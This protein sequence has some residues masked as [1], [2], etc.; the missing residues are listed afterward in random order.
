V[1]ALLF[2]HNGASKATAERAGLTLGW[3]AGRRHPDSTAVRLIYADR[4]LDD[5]RLN[6][7]VHVT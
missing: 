4:P 6:A 2:E 7:L 1:V 5:G 3:R